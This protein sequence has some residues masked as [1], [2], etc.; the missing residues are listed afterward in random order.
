MEIVMND[1]TLVAD[2]LSYTINSSLGYTLFECE[3]DNMKMYEDQ[4]RY[5]V[6]C[7]KY[8]NYPESNIEA[9]LNT[10]KIALGK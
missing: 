6:Y 3:P 2:F 5:F 7:I 9:S 10:L 8:N 4:M 1:E